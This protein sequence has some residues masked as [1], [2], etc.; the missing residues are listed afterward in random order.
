[1]ISIMSNRENHAELP[2]LVEVGI[3][4]ETTFIRIEIFLYF[5]FIQVSLNS[6]TL[7]VCMGMKS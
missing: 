6:A 1:M 3:M 7:Q 4:L 2:Q 5:S